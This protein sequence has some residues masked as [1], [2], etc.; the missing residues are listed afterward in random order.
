MTGI[1]FSIFILKTTFV[2]ALGST[3][4]TPQNLEIKITG[5]GK[6]AEENLKYQ[7]GTE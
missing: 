2:F 6:Q 7:V 1:I 4:P 3:R 5:W